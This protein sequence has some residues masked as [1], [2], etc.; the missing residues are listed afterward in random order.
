MQV[1]RFSDNPI[2]KPTLDESIGA[3]INGPSLLR[4]PDWLPNPLGQYY[5]YFAHHQGAFIRLA[6]ADALSGPWTIYPPGTLRL[7]QTPCYHHI[8]SP[9]LHID[10]DNRRIL[11]YYHGPSVRR[12]ELEADPLKQKYP[13]L[14]GQ[15][16]LLAVSENGLDFTSDTEILGPSYFRVFRY[17]DTTAGWYYALAMPGILF[18]SRDGRTN[19]EPG[20][21][22]FDRDQRHAALLLRDDILYVFY[23]RAGDCPEHI[24]CA[25]INLRPHWNEWKASAPFSILE[26]ETEYE[27]IDLPLEPSQRGA[28]HE[29]ARQLRD[30]GIYK[31][32]GRT[33]LL[34]SVAGES[35]IALAELQFN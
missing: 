27:G 35:G 9:D 23:S 25:T 29:P 19:F 30:P 2:I 16:S 6:Y 4:V 20:P 1:K 10:N 31:E 12:E 32:G 15:R 24:L 33:Y 28:I 11:M 17:P 13:F 21:V 7:E 26:P 5:L 22:L 34:Y 14:E 8:A 18:R 3:N